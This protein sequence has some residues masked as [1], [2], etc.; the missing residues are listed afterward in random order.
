VGE[1]E[2]VTRLSSWSVPEF[3]RVE[4][5]GCRKSHF[6]EWARQ[7]MGWVCGMDGA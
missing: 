4:D 7:V 2:R 5:S 1:R 6:V 3:S